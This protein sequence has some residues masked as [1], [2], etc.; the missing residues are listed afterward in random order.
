MLAP[1]AVQTDS[2]DGRGHRRQLA[3]VLNVVRE[4][5][6]KAPAVNTASATGDASKTVT[7]RG[8]PIL[9]VGYVNATVVSSFNLK[10]GATVIATLAN[11]LAGGNVPFVWI[12]NPGAGAFTYATDGA[13]H[14]ASASLTAI[15]LK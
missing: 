14:T 9:L 3:T 2:T 8:N 13:T 1:E 11:S 4:Y 5:L 6:F 15:E 12:D 10:R 7:C